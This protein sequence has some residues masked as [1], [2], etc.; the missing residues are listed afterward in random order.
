MSDGEIKIVYYPGC[1]LHTWASSLSESALASFEHLGIPFTELSKWTCCQAAFPLAKDNIMGVISAARILVAA[2]NEGDV[3][4]TLCSFCFNVLRR[5]NNAI[6]T[7]EHIKAKVNAY[8]EE[9]YKGDLDVL[10]PLEILRDQVGFENLK[11]KIERPLTG[12]KVSPYYGCQLVRPPE[13][14]DFDDAEDPQI[15]DDFLRAIGCD[16]VDSAF[17]VECCGSHLVLKGGSLVEEQGMR[18]L[19]NA[20][21]NGADAL[22]LS[23]PLCF[24]NLENRK[25]NIKNSFPDL[26]ELP[27]F[28]FTQLLG[29]AL[30]VSEDLNELKTLDLDPVP[31]LACKGLESDK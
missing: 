24:Y 11:A 23:C 25:E 31:V 27:V 17:K 8:L 12:L 2:R 14:M 18:I 28:Y 26:R 10:H 29:M 6:R 21:G 22:A 20:S 7:D 9:D 16:V 19:Q 4:T 5:T 15:M 1:T 13:E 3:L 30:G